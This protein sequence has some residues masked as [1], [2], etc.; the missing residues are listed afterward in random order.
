MQILAVPLHDLDK[1]FLFSKHQF[2]RVSNENANIYSTELF[3]SM[4][5]VH[6]MSSIQYAFSGL[7]L[8]LSL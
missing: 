6:I 8:L 1:L 5:Y 2:P 4:K 7:L 3:N